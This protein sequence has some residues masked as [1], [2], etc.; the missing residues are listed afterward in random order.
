MK[1]KENQ[2]I[3]HPLDVLNVGDNVNIQI[4]SIDKEHNKIQ[5]KI[6]WD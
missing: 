6:I 1:K 4:I 5:G 2:F 3:K